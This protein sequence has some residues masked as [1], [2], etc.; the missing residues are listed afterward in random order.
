MKIEDKLSRVDNSFTINMYDNGYMVEIGGRNDDDNWS[1]A[2]I[3]CNTLE[4]L[5][6]VVTEATNMPKD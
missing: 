4:D 2:R 6:K 1:T 3:M 5:L